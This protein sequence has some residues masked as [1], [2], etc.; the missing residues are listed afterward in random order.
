MTA[1]TDTAYFTTES[2]KKN[3]K[4]IRWKIIKE[5]RAKDYFVLPILLDFFQKFQTFGYFV[6]LI[7]NSQ[8]I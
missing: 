7:L 1:Q 2:W 8:Q 5:Q 6:W 4:K 3:V